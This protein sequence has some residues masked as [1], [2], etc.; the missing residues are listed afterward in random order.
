MNNSSI[1]YWIQASRPRAFPLS[2]ACIG[3]AGF[4]AA[5]IGQIHWGVLWMSFLTA[6]LLQL[7]SNLANDLGDF[8]NGADNERRKGPS[9]MVQSGLISSKAMKKAIAITASLSFCSGLYLIYLSGLSTG[10]I[11]FFILIGLL[12]IWSAIRYTLGSGAYGYRAMGDLFVFLF[13]GFVG[14]LG[15]YYLQ[16]HRFDIIHLLPACTCG[17]FAVSVLNINNI[18]DIHSDSVAGKKTLAVVLGPIKSRIYQGFMMFLGILLAALYVYLIGGRFYFLIVLPFFGA[19]FYKVWT[20]ESA[21]KLNP[22]IRDM[23]LASL[24]FVFFFGIGLIS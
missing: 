2:L 21:E 17:C 10:R 15:T 20:F 14:V 7:L 4:L 12:A 3:M 1:K 22:L 19:I 11:V 23:S 9:R 24:G 6:F 13:F 5:R 8:E 18:R 16:S